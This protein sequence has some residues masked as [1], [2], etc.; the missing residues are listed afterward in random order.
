MHSSLGV[1]V[2]W[3]AHQIFLFGLVSGLVET[4]DP[5]F[6]SDNRVEREVRLMK[7]E[8]RDWV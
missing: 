5:C 7:R 6:C 1:L 8:K 2:S 3:E 4:A